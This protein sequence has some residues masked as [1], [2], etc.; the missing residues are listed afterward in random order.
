MATNRRAPGRRRPGW[1]RAAAAGV[2]LAVVFS[3]TACVPSPAQTPATR[4][5]TAVPKTT[6][7]PA[8]TPVELGYA[9]VDTVW[10]AAYAGTQFRAQHGCGCTLKD[11][12]NE[13]LFPKGTA[14]VVLKITMTGLWKPAQGKQTTQTVTGATVSGTKFDGRPE[15]AVLDT[16]DG[17]RYAKKLGLPWLPS[18]LFHD[19]SE[20]TIH[21][22]EPSAFAAAW[23][24]PT[25]VDRLDLVVNIPSEG[26]PTEVFITLPSSVLKLSDPSQE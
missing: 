4:H 12:S 14:V 3:L 17:P 20:W 24:V 13:E 10:V 25:G 7:T 6:P 22:N 26:K 18:G 5:L 16:K 15:D 2:G 1:W 11:D 8:A 21:N 9:A 23:Y 19:D